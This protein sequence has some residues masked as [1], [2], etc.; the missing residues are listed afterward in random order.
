MGYYSFFFCYQIIENI[1]SLDWAIN[2]LLLQF[3]DKGRC[4]GHYKKKLNTCMLHG[5]FGLR[6]RT[7]TSQSSQAGL[8]RVKA[9]FINVLKAKIYHRA[10]C[11]HCKMK[12][13]NLAPKMGPKRASP[14]WYCSR[15]NSA[16]LKWG[17]F[18]IN[19]WG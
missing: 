12:R 6:Q 13:A 5:L 14:D 2:S 1:V 11:L 7:Q 8:N 18:G 16:S 15:A 19:F 4:S 3:S 10:E 9:V 17:C